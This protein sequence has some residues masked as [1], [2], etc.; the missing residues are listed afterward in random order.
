MNFRLDGHC[1]SVFHGLK[2]W[3]PATIVQKFEAQRAIYTSS[4]NLKD[5]KEKDPG[6]QEEN[7]PSKIP[8]H[9]KSNKKHN[10]QPIKG[11]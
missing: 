8:N 4:E 9:I 10:E 7:P 2:R 1:G 6:K 3:E 5:G 11:K